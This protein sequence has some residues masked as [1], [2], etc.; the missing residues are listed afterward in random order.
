MS[1]RVLPAPLAGQLVV[2]LAVRLVD[3]GDLGDERVIGIRVAQQRTDGQQDLRYREGGGPLRPQNVQADGSVAVDVGM[4]DARREGDFRGLEGVVRG[5]V[6]GE[7]EHPSLV[8]TVRR[9]HDRRLPVEEIVA[10][11]SC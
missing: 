4:V 6:D 8:G 10:D 1:H 5:K 3:A 7:E 11:W 9:A 2:L